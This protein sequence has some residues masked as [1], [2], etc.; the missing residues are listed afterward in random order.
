MLN[1]LIAYVTGIMERAE[2][3]LLKGI[4]NEQLYFLLKNLIFLLHFLQAF[5]I[6]GIPQEIK[7]DNGS[8]YTSHKIKQFFNQWGINHTTSIP[9]SPVGQSIFERAHGSHK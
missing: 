8:A 9:H 1:I 6:L 7:M 2:N 4:A 3:S 5:A